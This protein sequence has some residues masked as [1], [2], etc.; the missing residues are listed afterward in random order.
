MTAEDNTSQAAEIEGAEGVVFHQ[1][2]AEP[3]EEPASYLT[4]TVFTKNDCWRCNNVE[5]RF[6]KDGVPYEEINVETD[7]EPREEFGGLTPFEHVVKNYGREMPVIVVEDDN[8]G[9]WWTAIRPDKMI[10]TKQRFADA[11]MLIPEEMRSA[12]DSAQL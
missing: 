8:W 10:E 2:P 3:A 11:G 6:D 1:P 12:R 5:S 9:D 7:T 4:V